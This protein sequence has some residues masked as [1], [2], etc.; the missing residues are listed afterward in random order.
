LGSE[1]AVRA[2]IPWD[3]SLRSS[4]VSEYRYK[5]R[6]GGELRCWEANSAAL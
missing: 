3:S 1:N 4:Y 5:L 2:A 6:S